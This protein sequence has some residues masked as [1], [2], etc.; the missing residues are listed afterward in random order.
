MGAPLPPAHGPPLNATEPERLLLWAWRPSGFW[1]LLIPERCEGQTTRANSQMSTLPTSLEMSAKS[2][3]PV[4]PTRQ[5]EGSP[6]LGRFRLLRELRTSNMQ[7]Q[8]MPVRAL[9]VVHDT[10]QRTASC[11]LESGVLQPKDVVFIKIT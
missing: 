6:T 2:V 1:L 4:Q 5:R 10:Y 3:L 7:Q 8:N 11:A 9:P